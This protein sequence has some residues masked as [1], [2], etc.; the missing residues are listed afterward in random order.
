MPIGPKMEIIM[1]WKW[2]DVL[3]S[4]LACSGPVRAEDLGAEGFADSKG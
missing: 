3:G 1:K 2:M 4:L